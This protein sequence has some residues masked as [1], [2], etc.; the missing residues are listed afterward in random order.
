MRIH[1]VGM[2]RQNHPL[3]AACDELG[4]LRCNIGRFSIARE[5]AGQ[6]G[7]MT[8]YEQADVGMGGE[9]PAQAHTVNAVHGSRAGLLHREFDLSGVG[10]A[11]KSKQHRLWTRPT[12]SP[13]MCLAG[14]L[15][16]SETDS[17]AF[18]KGKMGRR[19]RNKSEPT[20]QSGDSAWQ[21]GRRRPPGYGAKEPFARHVLRRINRTSNVMERCLG[22]TDNQKSR[23]SPVA[24]SRRKQMPC[25]VA[26]LAIDRRDHVAVQNGRVPW[27]E[28]DKCG[29][30]GSKSQR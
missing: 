6:L 7:V 25:P 22:T 3:L 9:V 2:V 28:A 11:G 19:S 12:F 27:P 17:R 26:E 5:A 29:A 1:G 16:N 8:A 24:I 4:G 14:P 23:I 15:Q 20:G 21:A 30:P 13:P 18:P 10:K